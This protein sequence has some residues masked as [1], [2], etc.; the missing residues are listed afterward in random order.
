M[1]QA[2]G[3]S[4]LAGALSFNDHSRLSRLYVHNNPLGP[5]GVEE[6]GKF[7]QDC[8]KVRHNSCGARR[9]RC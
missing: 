9:V 5:E 8:P 1:L 3:A 4:E 7:L 6:L 2:E